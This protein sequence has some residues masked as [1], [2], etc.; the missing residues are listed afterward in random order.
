MIVFHCARTTLLCPLACPKSG[1]TH[2]CQIGRPFCASRNPVACRVR[3]AKLVEPSR[4]HLAEVS[5]GNFRLEFGRVMVTRPSHFTGKQ[6]H[7]KTCYKCRRIAPLATRLH[8]AWRFG[9]AHG[10]FAPPLGRSFLW[11]TCCLEV[12]SSWGRGPPMLIT[13]GA[14]ICG[15]ASGAVDLPPPPVASSW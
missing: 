1:V 14:M 9:G 8:G 7:K 2:G 15:V 5:C 6:Q 13:I 11:K 12:T 10:V 4:R 3:Y